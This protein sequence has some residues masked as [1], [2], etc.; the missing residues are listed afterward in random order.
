MKTQTI[1]ILGAEY[2]FAV[3]S[4]KDDPEFERLG[5]D[6]Y[7]DGPIR[8]MVVCD[9]KTHPDYQGETPQ[10]CSEYQKV[11]A[12]HEIE[13]A[14]LYQSGL[15]ASSFIPRNGWAANEEMVD[16]HAHQGPKIYAAWKQ[17]GAL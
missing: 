14:F 17:V 15:C 13:H 8:L 9:L 4:Y 6:G 1:S 10:H 11:V 12:R 2:L 16:W 7:H 3:R 5:C